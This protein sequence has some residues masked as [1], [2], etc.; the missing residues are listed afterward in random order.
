MNILFQKNTISFQSKEKIMKKK[1]IQDLVES[2]VIENG[3]KVTKYKYIA[4]KYSQG[5][6][7]QKV[8]FLLKVISEVNLVVVVEKCPLRREY[9]ENSFFYFRRSSRV[10]NRLYYYIDH[11]RGC[12]IMDLF[13]IIE[14][15]GDALQAL[16]I[17][18]G[19]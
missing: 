13:L 12:D 8:L 17:L 6:F 7:I 3:V 11:T 10:F 19:E 14:V 18:L 16:L 1:K 2:V 4:P 5:T 15:S 9:R